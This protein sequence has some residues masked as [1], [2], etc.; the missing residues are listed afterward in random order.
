M[1]SAKRRSGESF[2]DYRK[3]LKNEAKE[4]KKRLKGEFVWNSCAIV[5]NPDDSG[6]PENIR[7]AHKVIQQGTYRKKKKGE[8]LK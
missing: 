3:R 6:I 5:Y 8:S 4:L 7:P 1:S 2:D